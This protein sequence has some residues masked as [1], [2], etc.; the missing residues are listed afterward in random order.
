MRVN[1][2]EAR[3]CNSSA[4]TWAK[5]VPVATSRSIVDRPQALNHCGR[6]GHGR[7]GLGIVALETV[8]HRGAFSR[9]ADRSIFKKTL[10]KSVNVSACDAA[11]AA[12]YM[13]DHGGGLDQDEAVSTALQLQ[14]DLKGHKA[15]CP[16]SIA[17]NYALS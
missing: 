16:L 3:F 1:R 15:L 9:S 11:T 4:L 6:N 2:V 7:E 13:Y 10:R 5:L 17:E 8:E 12:R 14:Q